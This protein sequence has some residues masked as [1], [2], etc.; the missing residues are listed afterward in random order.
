[1]RIC[2]A[3]GAA[4]DACF[5]APTLLADDFHT[6]R[7]PPGP[8][9]GGAVPNPGFELARLLATLKSASGR[10]LVD[11]FYDRVREAEAIPCDRARFLAEVGGRG[12]VGAAG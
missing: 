12:I 7:D 5:F 1:M 4:R 2:W 6:G 8:P 3:E 11:G 10:V 9:G